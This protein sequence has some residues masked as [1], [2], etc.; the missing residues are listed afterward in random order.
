MKGDL[1]STA[2]FESVATKCG[3]IGTFVSMVPAGFSYWP[4]SS[5]SSGLFPHS[6]QDHLYPPGKILNCAPGRGRLSV[7]SYIHPFFQPAL[8]L[9]GSWGSFS[10]SLL[11][12]HAFTPRDT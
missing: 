8:S 11:L 3:I 2:G 4:V 9:L 7:I 1:W 5:S 6:S 12:P 10:L